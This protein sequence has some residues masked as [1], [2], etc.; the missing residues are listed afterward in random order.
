MF[1]TGSYS[2]HL[3]PP[4]PGPEHQSNEPFFWLK[5]LLETRRSSVFRALYWPFS[6]S[7]TRFMSQQPRFAQKSKNCKKAWVSHWRLARSA[8]TRRENMLANYSNPRKT[9]EVLQFALK[10]NF[11]DLGLWM[12]PRFGYVLLFFGYSFMT[13]SPGQWAEIVAQSLVVF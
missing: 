10:K 4:L 3:R 6:I 12:S 11:W 13:S 7:G 8:I 9:R 5:T 1:W 2:L